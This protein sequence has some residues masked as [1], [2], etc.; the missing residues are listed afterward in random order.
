MKISAERY[1]HLTNPH[2]FLFHN[3]FVGKGFLH[4]VSAVAAIEGG[5]FTSQYAFA[6]NE[7]GKEE[8]FERVRSENYPE[9]PSRLN[10]FF[11]FPSVLYAERA[12]VEWFGG[13]KKEMLDLH[14][15]DGAAIHT[16][17]SKQLN[18]TPDQWEEMAH[19]YWSGD[20]TDDPFLETIVHGAVFFPGWEKPPF[21]LLTPTQYGPA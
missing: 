1:W 13:A 12:I 15:V 20:L 6:N 14:I 11:C 18:A 19:K 10:A 4:S 8:A 17:D 2:D 9:R 3:V 7:K 5:D 21:G 16:A